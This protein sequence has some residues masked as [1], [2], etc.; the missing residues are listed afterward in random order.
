MATWKRI[1]TEGDVGPGS[2]TDTSLATHN[3]VLESNRRIVAEK[4]R[5][6]EI[7]GDADTGDVFTS[8]KIAKFSAVGGDNGSIAE[9]FGETVISPY[10]SGGSSFNQGFLKFLENP[11]QGTQG[12]SVF[13]PYAL[14]DD[15]SFSLPPVP[16]NLNK[17]HFLTLEEVSGFDW[18]HEWKWKRT[19]DLEEVGGGTQAGVVVG[20]ADPDK[21]LMLVHD[22]DANELK[23]MDI[24][25][26]YAA[27]TVSLFQALVDAGFGSN[28]LYTGS[29]G[30][31]G[32]VN[33]DG[34]VS[35]GDLLEF[36]TQFGMIES[37]SPTI[38]E[39]TTCPLT[40]HE[41]GGFSVLKKLDIGT[42]DAAVTTGD[43]NVNVNVGQD[44]FTI[45]EGLNNSL[46]QYPNKTIFV[47]P[48]DGFETS[49]I[50]ISL[51]GLVQETVHLYVRIEG[52]SAGGSQINA[53]TEDYL[54]TS[55]NPTQV[56]GPQTYPIP[57]TEIPGNISGINST[58]GGAVASLRISFHAQSAS[59]FVFGVG[60][61]GIKFKLAVS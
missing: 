43:F 19:E 4:A 55:I 61:E 26:L 33:N 1:L 56:P 28:E 22:V 44:H 32:D 9:F 13:A 36:L 60:I 50:T 2:L 29:G 58:G 47:E 24:Q 18:D 30:L 52:F 46:T 37:A 57:I 45:T 16:S 35:S 21:F 3:Q 53:A 8:P 7:L 12:V 42:G 38:V 34:V 23:K 54:L 48:A 10:K 11:T 14:S 20:E 17:G 6:L 49:A 15:E 31:S 51:A 5:F 39:L 41:G 59:G 25:E 27:I 40:D